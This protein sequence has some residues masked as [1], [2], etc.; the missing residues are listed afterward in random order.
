MLGDRDEDGQRLPLL[1]WRPPRPVLAIASS[2]LG[3]GIGHR[4]WIIN[5]TV[6]SAYSRLDPA[7]H[8]AELARGLD[9][10]GPG[11]GLLTAVDVHDA[12][13]ATDGGVEVTATVGLG[14]P[15][16]AAA[17]DGDLRHHAPGAGTINLVAWLPVPLTASALVNAVSTAT[18]AK[19]Q[20]LIDCGV[21][22][23][24]TATDA[25][26]LACPPQA[27]PPPAG[28]GEASDGGFEDGEAYGGPRSIW[29]ARLARAV[30]AAVVAGVRRWNRPP[31]ADARV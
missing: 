7:A 25:M 14:H 26:C 8:L 30:H 27:C 18:E 16:W 5:A 24:G 13:T 20:A 4:G 23:T 22:A 31:E 2:P 9:L 12:V 10:D 17:P 19:V 15:T 6:P 3:G 11:V 21:G 29:G 1:V 28:F